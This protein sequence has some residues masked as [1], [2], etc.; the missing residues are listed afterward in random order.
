[1]DQFKSMRAFLDDVSKKIGLKINAK[2]LYT[3]KGKLIQSMEQINDNK[4]FICFIMIF[5]I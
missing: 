5:K 2:K 3:L 4:V 1:M